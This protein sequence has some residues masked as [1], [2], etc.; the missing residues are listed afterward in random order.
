MQ[1]QHDHAEEHD[2]FF[3][4]GALNHVRVEEKRPRYA[5]A[6]CVLFLLLVLVISV[7]VLAPKR[8]RH[9]A[10]SN[11]T[12]LESFVLGEDPEDDYTFPFADRFNFDN[13]TGK[14]VY[15]QQLGETVKYCAVASTAQLSERDLKIK[16][17][18]CGDGYAFRNSSSISKPFK[19]LL[20]GSAWR[21]DNVR[22]LSG[23]PLG[24]GKCPLSPLCT[25]AQADKYSSSQSPPDVTVVFQTQHQ[26]QSN[27]RYRVLYWREAMFPGP[28]TLEGFDFEMGVHLFAGLPNPYFME[29]PREYLLKVNGALMPSLPVTN[30]QPPT[31]FAISII[32]HCG[33]ASQR[34]EYLAMI[35]KLL[36][37][38]QLNV[39]EYGTCGK[40]LLPSKP[41]GRANEIISSY[42]FYFSLE[43]ELQTGYVTEKLL[44]IL[45][46]DGPIPVYFGS[47][48]LRPNI[49][50]SKS[51]ISAS[52][53]STT[54]ELV[55]HLIDLDQN[56]TKWQ[57]YK[58]WR[59]NRDFTDEYLGI[60]SQR[61][62]GPEELLAHA[63][64]NPKR[65]PRMAQC[66][67]L[68]DEQFVQFAQRT[69]TLQQIGKR[70][71][72]QEIAKRYFH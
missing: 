42:K 32:S 11:S 43:N 4:A 71:S 29:T 12:D 6:A 69:K 62:A 27:S 50:L 5:I 15:E 37:P 30:S 10:D 44:Y 14:R 34:D 46:L 35:N 20:L 57:E 21:K 25:F 23:C 70:W 53:F 41:L 26:L 66:C 36:K 48:G 60:M 40:L 68:C 55:D 24:E 72:K 51:F 16:Q 2:S 58:Q 18:D 39:D 56:D 19:V 54:Q 28:L 3:A 47:P 8:Q 49:T 65:F 61:I 22:D 13:L 1:Q 17:A 45:A 9:Q 63:K 52:E 38:Q 59:I 33:A 31:K 64:S 67:R 7:A